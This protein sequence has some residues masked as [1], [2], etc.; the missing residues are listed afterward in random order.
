MKKALFVLVLVLVA[1]LLMAGGAKEQAVQKA[2][3][4]APG[5]VRVLLSKGGSGTV[6]G[7]GIKAFAASAGKQ[8]EIIEYPYAEVREKQLLDLTPR[9]A[10]ST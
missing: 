3:T 2:Q 8:V 5:P 9:P 10:T 1:M 4:D 6:I 7:N